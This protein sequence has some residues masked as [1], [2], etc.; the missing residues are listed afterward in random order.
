MKNVSV[1]ELR[2]QGYRVFVR[3]MRHFRLGI[4]LNHMVIPMTNDV[5]LTRSQIGET[6]ETFS[7]NNNSIVNIET[8]SRG[9]QTEV[10]VYIGDNLVARGV[11]RCSTKDAYNKKVGR[12][13]ALGRALQGAINVAERQQQLF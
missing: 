13:I 4:E 10:E 1:A 5:P 11:A 12:T 8:L 6:V 7:S 9:G 3:H 2:A